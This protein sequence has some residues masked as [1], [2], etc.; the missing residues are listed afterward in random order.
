MFDRVLQ[1]LRENKG[2]PVRLGA[3]ISPPYENDTL[4][5]EIW[6]RPYPIG[7][8]PYKAAPH[9]CDILVLAGLVQYVWA[10]N[11]LT[12]RRVEGAELIHS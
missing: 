9:V 7:N 2:R 5:T 8:S 12:G 4:E 11:L 1:C 10:S 3:K 6:K